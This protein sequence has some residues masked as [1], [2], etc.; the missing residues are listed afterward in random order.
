MNLKTFIIKQY[1]NHD[2]IEHI[3]GHDILIYIKTAIKYL[4]LLAIIFLVYRI[5]RLYWLDEETIA[6]VF[7]VA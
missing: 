6:L 2:D 5:V 4:A 3:I 1:V 7:G